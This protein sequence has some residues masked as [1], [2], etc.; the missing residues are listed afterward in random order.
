MH[1]RCV[2][3][4]C[5]LGR[6]F[7]W[8]LFVQ[9]YKCARHFVRL[10]IATSFNPARCKPDRPFN[11]G[12]HNVLSSVASAS[13]V[14]LHTI[15]W[16][17]ICCVGWQFRQLGAFAD[18]INSHMRKVDCIRGRGVSMLSSA[19]LSGSSS[20]EGVATKACATYLAHLTAGLRVWRLR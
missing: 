13:V 20:E 18:R 6:H 16:H 2:A 11:D 15:A 5:A 7:R 3:S 4:I 12:Q 19:L 10:S 8:V 9:T 14:Q 1:V 17:W